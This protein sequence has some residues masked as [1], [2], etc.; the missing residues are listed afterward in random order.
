LNSQ[1][2]A[3]RAKTRD[4]F[5]SNAGNKRHP[6][7]L[8]FGYF[9]LAKQRKVTCSSVRK[10]TYKNPSRQQIARNAHPQLNSVEILEHIKRATTKPK[11]IKIFRITDEDKRCSKKQKK[12]KN[13]Q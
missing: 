7:G 12:T 3:R 6:G 5:R 13:Y 10:P 8:S 4:G 11:T 2:L 1:Q 9:S